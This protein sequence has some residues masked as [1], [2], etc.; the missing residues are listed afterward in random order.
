MKKSNILA[1]SSTALMMA[2]SG[3]GGESANVIPEPNI[4]KEINGSCV[5]GQNCVEFALDYPVD[6]LNFTCSSDP[7]KTYITLIAPTTNAATGKCS[8]GDKVHFFIQEKTEK[9]INLGTVSLAD[10]GLANSVSAS[11]PRLTLLDIARGLTGQAATELTPSDST[12]QVAQ[13][14]TRI[15]QALSIESS[16]NQERPTIAGDVQPLYISALKKEQ[17]DDILGSV[18][19]EDYRSG[20]YVSKLSPWVDLSTVS[21][22]QAFDALKTLVYMTNSASYQANYPVLAVEGSTLPQGLYGCNQDDCKQNSNTLRHLIGQ[23]QLMTDRSGYTFGYGMQWRGTM[24]TSNENPLLTITA[25]FLK[26]VRPEL[27]TA[28]AQ[29]NWINPL[30]ETIQGPYRF[31]INSNRTE[32]F[33]VTQGKLYND[34]M[35][36]GTEGIYKTL[37]KFPTGKPEEYGRWTQ[38]I[39]TDQFKGSLD[40]YKY[41]QV[42]FLDNRIFTSAKNVA[43][44]ERYIFPLYATLNFNFANNAAPA[45]KLGIVLDEQGNI[46]TD[47]GPNPTATD[48]S[49]TC[50]VATDSSTPE[51]VDSN[52]VTQYRIG[53]LGATDLSNQAITLR[54]ILANPVFNQLNGAVIGLNTR[55][56]NT[57]GEQAMVVGGARL[58]MGNL[59]NHTSTRISLSDFSGNNTVSWSNLYTLQLKTFT[60]QDSNNATDADKELAKLTGGTVSIEVADCYNPEQVRIQ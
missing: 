38:T 15:L 42:N 16:K 28:A 53:V 7:S 54:M 39:G 9:S 22:A 25:D 55:V 32:D 57:Q 46:R 19:L 24:S 17:L 52:N 60:N 58:N 51:I 48:L 26:R 12:V 47:I 34:Y 2:L 13:A 37:T 40:I 35:I 31:S 59:V 36:A 33:T 41:F 43:L 49:G 6:G 8:A 29:N 4:V 21:D 23:F 44:G 11:L 20:A 27:M 45:I 3:C 10:I 5:S 30:N 1:L 50:A 14:I 18:T 56:D